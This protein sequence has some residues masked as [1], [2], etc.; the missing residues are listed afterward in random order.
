MYFDSEKIQFSSHEQ[1][2]FLHFEYLNEKLLLCGKEILDMINWMRSQVK[3][4]KEIQANL[5]R[6]EE[7]SNLCFQEKKIRRLSPEENELKKRYKEENYEDLVDFCFIC[8][9]KF[10]IKF[11][12]FFDFFFDFMLMD[13]VMK[14]DQVRS[15]EG[16]ISDLLKKQEKLELRIKNLKIEKLKKI[17]KMKKNQKKFQ[18]KL[19]KAENGFNENLIKEISKHEERLQDMEESY[20]RQLIRAKH[21]YELEKQKNFTM[22]N[23]IEKIVEENKQKDECY[24]KNT[25]NLLE[26]YH[27]QFKI[28]TEKNEEEKLKLKKEHEIEM[29]NLKEKLK[30][31]SQDILEK[32]IGECKKINQKAKE[33]FEKKEMET[34]N[35]HSKIVKNTKKECQKLVDEVIKIKNF[36]RVELGDFYEKNMKKMKQ[37]VLIDKNSEFFF[38]Q[39]EMLYKKNSKVIKKRKNYDFDFKLKKDALMLNVETVLKNQNLLVKE[40]ENLKVEFVGMKGTNRS[41]NW[42]RRGK[43]L[44]KI[45]SNLENFEKIMK[46]SLKKFENGINVLIQ[47]AVTM[48]LDIKNKPKTVERSVQ[49]IQENPLENSLKIE[50]NPN[51]YDYYQYCE[52]GYKYFRNSRKDKLS[53]F[54]GNY[55]NQIFYKN[56]NFKEGIILTD[57]RL[58]IL[59][60]VN[61]VINS[62]EGKKIF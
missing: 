22:Q 49:T 43:I 45:K 25:Q 51:F 56:S 31:R 35:E 1:I 57:K 59:R 13:L 50:N 39:I 10:E 29:Q 17:E 42:Q 4:Y 47:Q 2:K 36:F 48:P 52:E 24:Q 18:E 54:K 28:F 38:K 14:E 5:I 46:K 19:K 60:N 20:K 15:N 6:C 3:F 41:K 11:E 58:A 37:G 32:T 27:N 21:D 23:L 53:I 12:E 55:R 8:E 44:E 16:L 40:I 30:L 62:I 34:K 33:K 61:N 26:N 9:E 7:I